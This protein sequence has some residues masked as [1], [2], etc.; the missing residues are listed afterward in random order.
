MDV[1][2]LMKKY[3]NTS[4]YLHIWACWI[5]QTSHLVA[6]HLIPV[7]SPQSQHHALHLFCT[8]TVTF[9]L[10]NSACEIQLLPHQIWCECPKRQEHCPDPAQHPKTYYT[11]RALHLNTICY[12]YIT[13]L[14]SSV[15]C[16]SI[17]DWLQVPEQSIHRDTSNVSILQQDGP[18][19]LG[20]KAVSSKF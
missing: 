3:K 11:S 20:T 5:N 4:L 17:S 13:Q 8:V 7:I 10:N 19:T 15:A 6:H 14:Q 18:S 12:Q 1:V 9:S 2:Y 16:T